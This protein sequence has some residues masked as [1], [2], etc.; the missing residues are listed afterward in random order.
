MFRRLLSGMD[1]ATD[2]KNDMRHLIQPRG[3]GKSRVF[4]MLT[5]PDLVGLP[6]PWNGKPFRKEIRKGLGTNHLRTARRL[7]D[8]APGD[9]R[10]L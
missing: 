2:G 1:H 3:A 4:R 5:P 9:I 10:R 8:I 6:K 7:R